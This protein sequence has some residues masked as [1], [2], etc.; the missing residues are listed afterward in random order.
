[1]ITKSTDVLLKSKNRKRLILDVDFTEDPADGNQQY[2]A[3]NGHF[4][5]NWF[6]PLLRYV[7]IAGQC[8]VESIERAYF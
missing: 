3:Y 8:L 2:M 1:M 4:G 5:K 6:H 7:T